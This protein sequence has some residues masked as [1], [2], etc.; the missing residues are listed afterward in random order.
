VGERVRADGKFLSLGCTPFR[1]RGVTYGTFAAR[2]DG[3]LFPATERVM[4]DFKSIA[5]L[6]LNTVRVY[7]VPPADVLA[8]ADAAGLRLIVGVH[9]ED[10][11]YEPVAGRHARARVERSGLAAVE[12]AME[13]LAG[14]TSVLAVSVGNEVPA[15]VVRV[16]GRREVAAGLSRLVDAV[17]DADAQV[18][19]TYTNFPSTEYLEVEGQDLVTFNVFLERPEAFR[20]YLRHLHVV[21]GERPLVLTETGIAGDRHGED[22]QADALA[23]QLRFVDEAGCAGATVFAWTDEWH[24]GADP[25][26]GWGFGITDAERRPKPAVGVLEG[27]ARCGIADLRDE[28]PRV[29]VIV[30]AH[31]A[32]DTIEECL[33]SLL[34]CD[35]PELDVVVCED[36]STDGTDVIAAGYPFRLV[37]LDHIG[38][39]AARNAGVRA[40]K[41]EIVAFI[42]ADA[43][44]HPEWPYHLALSLEDQDVAATGGPN[45]PVEDA[46][47]VER[48]VSA[49]PGGP[50]E[51]LVSH[52]R[53]EHVPG[54]NMA[55]RKQALED[56]GGF[57]PVYRSAGDDVDVCWKLLDRGDEI[58]FAPAAQ[59]RHH[60]RGTV[61]E[62]LRQQRGYG[63]AER[64]LAAHHRHRFNSLG[65]ARWSGF[66][67]GG[68]RVLRSLLRPVVYH[69]YQGSAPFQKVMYRRAEVALGWASALLPF[70]VPLALLGGFA[71]LTRWA[72]VAPAIALLALVAYGCAVAA[73]THVPRDEPRSLRFRTLVAALHL[74][75]PFVRTWGRLSGPALPT[76]ETDLQTVWVGDRFEWLGALTRALR[77]GGGHVRSG[78]PHDPWDLECARGWFVKCRIATAVVWSWEPLRRLSY[79]PRVPAVAGGALLPLALFHPVFVVLLAL[80]LLGVVVETRSLRRLVGRA[81]A[82][83]TAAAAAAHEQPEDPPGLAA[84]PGPAVRRANVRLGTWRSG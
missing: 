59:V 20:A 34:A 12:R 60:R 79:R 48:A 71:V 33:D 43:A 40:A 47:L 68:V 39:S 78:G 36:G 63:R 28:W 1:V 29:S 83:T 61:R 72:L 14:R 16:H 27:W 42:D 70:T 65:Q 22:A 73:G 75:Q 18:L 55:Y 7:G 80:L 54:C 58:A 41:G 13:T 4:D 19:A 23:W 52:D 46:P 38:L 8:A 53:A 6:G 24:V 26:E 57:D 31:N 62:Y 11:R 67:Y 17:H 50:V 5:R 56:I 21:A 81:L 37:R 25:V 15:D 82:E 3:M 49:S 51:V 32:A 44:C 69:G 76:E 30:C 74:A 9:Y 45:L 10:W 84:A 35:Y 77:A 64:L 66:V 2:S